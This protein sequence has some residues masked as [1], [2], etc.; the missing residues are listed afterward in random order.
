MAAEPT[1]GGNPNFFKTFKGRYLLVASAGQVVDTDVV[2]LSSTNDV[3]PIGD[4]TLADYTANEPFAVLPDE[5]RPMK[6]VKIPVVVNDGSDRIVVM[7]VK[8]DGT[9]TLPFDYE[10]ATLYLSGISLNISDNWY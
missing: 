6:T 10:S 8:P 7:T 5:C 3:Q 2:M 1:G 4:W 9:M